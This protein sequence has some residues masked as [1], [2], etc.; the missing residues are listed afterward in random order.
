MLEVG[1]LVGELNQ[2]LPERKFILMGPGRWGSRGDIKL[3][4]KVGY[5]D[6]NNTSMMIEIAR[7]KLDYTPDLSFGTHF[8]Q[9]L[10]EAN[11]KYLPL[12]PDEPGNHFLE[13]FFRNAPNC[14]KR[15][16]GKNVPATIDNV[17]RIIHIPAIADGATMSIIMDG[18]QNKAMGYLNRQNTVS[19]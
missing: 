2:R 8:F 19:A 12:Y 4:V 1:R 5:S 6:I 10:V 17:L 3:G 9:D 15:F 18:D 16:A 14:L 7:R 11:I 13:E